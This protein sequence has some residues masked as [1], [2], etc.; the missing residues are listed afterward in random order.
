MLTSVSEQAAKFYW[1]HCI[2][3]GN[4]V[5]T[6]GDY[7]MAQYLPAFHLPNLFEKR[8]LDVGRASGFFAFEFERQGADVT[9]TEIASFLDWDFVGGDPE[10]E[11][12]RER[13]GDVKTFTEHHITGAFK[14]AHRLRG[15][16]VRPVT[17]TIYNIS[18]ETV[19]GQFDVVFAGSV[20][21]HL[22]DPILGMERF[23]SV[24]KPGG[25]C[26]VSAPYVGLD[27][28]LAAAAMV[29]TMDTDRRSWW[30]FNKKCLT[31]LLLGAGFTTV[32]I[33]GSFN[34][35]LKRRASGTFPHIVAH[36]RA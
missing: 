28:N 26:V 24:T 2:D 5:V 33:V 14:F 9:A 1:Y 35:E 3:L 18:P 17:T 10:R 21:S 16:K 13:I 23:R 32:D 20:T 30:V 22:R 4:G 25:L 36:A 11:R 31:E 27:E 19:G 15:S 12:Q 8:V 6:D 29:G 7:E 34:L